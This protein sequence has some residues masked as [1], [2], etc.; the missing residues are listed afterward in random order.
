MISVIIPVYNGENTITRCLNSVVEQS[1]RKLEIIVVDDG[2]TDHT[3]TVVKKFCQNFNHIKYVYQQ[4]QGVSVARNTGIE[5]SSG[6]YILF[7]DA[8]DWVE[9]EY[10]SSLFK[11]ISTENADMSFSSWI[12]DMDKVMLYDS[13]NNYGYQFDGSAQTMFQFYITHRT[14]CAPWGKLFKRKI[15]ESE[16]IRF[17]QG[18]PIAEDY[19]FLLHYLSV[20]KTVAEDSNALIHYVLDSTGANYKVRKDYPEIQD[21]IIAEMKIINQ[22]TIYR[23]DLLLATAE[24]KTYCRTLMY[25]KKIKRERPD[26]NKVQENCINYINGLTQNIDVKLMTGSEKLLYAFV[27]NRMLRPFVRLLIIIL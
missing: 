14:G 23:N 16:H 5:T 6:E 27:K 9:D 26:N 25:L 10:I 22:M 4:N 21:Q 11:V 1:Y 7:I 20:S 3:A 8:D 24:V 2:S 19:L 12:I 15:I 18:L 17:K 13:L